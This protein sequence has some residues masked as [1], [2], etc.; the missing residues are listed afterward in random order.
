[1]LLKICQPYDGMQMSL[2]REEKMMNAG[3]PQYAR[4]SIGPQKLCYVVLVK[5]K[6]KSV[7][8]KKGNSQRYLPTYNQN[9]GKKHVTNVVNI[10]ETQFII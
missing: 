8:C 10:F 1:M 7:V 9:R 4:C 2:P 3:A 5:Q 6:Y